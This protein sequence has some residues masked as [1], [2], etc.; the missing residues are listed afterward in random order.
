[1]LYRN[2]SYGCEDFQIL[3][4]LSC[5]GRGIYL[6]FSTLYYS[7][8]GPSITSQRSAARAARFALATLKLRIFLSRRYGL[9]AVSQVRESLAEQYHYALSQAVAGGDSA[10][11]NEAIE[12]WNDVPRKQMRTL[13][14]RIPLFLPGGSGLVRGFKNLIRPSMF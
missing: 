10:V 1:D 6:P 7:V 11:I 4:T 5:A 2:K 13:L 8:G 3:T 9:S 12:M 14:L